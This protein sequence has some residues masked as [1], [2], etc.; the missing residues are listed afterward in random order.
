MRPK[1]N[2]C[3]S[4]L[5]ISSGAAFA[6]ASG[7]LAQGG[8]DANFEDGPSHSVYLALVGEEAGGEKEKRPAEKGA[9]RDT[10][11]KEKKKE[12]PYHVEADVTE[13]YYA[14]GD[15]VLHG[16]GNVVIVHG[17]TT[18]TCD[19]AYSYEAQRLATLLGKV[20]VRNPVQEYTLTAGYAEYHREDK[21][22]VATK[23]PR[24]VLEK[25]RPIVITSDIMRMWTD[26]EYGEAAGSVKIVSEDVDGYGQK[27]K[28][29]GKEERV[30]LS[31]KPVVRQEESRLAGDLI[32]LY[33]EGEKLRR[34]L[35]EGSAR[36]LYFSRPE[37]KGEEEEAGER[38]APGGTTAAAY[39]A[40]PARVEEELVD[41]T[42]GERIMAGTADD[43]D[44][45]GVDVAAGPSGGAAGEEEENG[46]PSGRVEAA[47]TVIDGLFKDGVL[48]QVDITG[49]AEGHY[50]PFD[51][52]GVETGEQIDAA[53]DRIRIAMNDGEVKKIVVE[54]NAE[55]IYRPAKSEGR[56]GVTQ[57]AGDRISVFVSEREVRRIVVFG[58]AHGSY[59][60]EETPAAE[61]R[62]VSSG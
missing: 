54:G 35:V 33:L 41:E 32:T 8:G 30:E 19:E 25:D 14:A 37:E 53:G 58:H 23:S 43:E 61:G 48:E 49:D 51:E 56:S 44:E 59:F 16:I 27:L 9:A 20:K 21:L 57:T 2:L 11:E 45:A 3:L 50:W 26:E 46:T 4:I 38:E 17:D 18:I 15:Q 31:G 34:A 39:E 47:G 40:A 12:I 29:F 1:R 5:L 6:G 13:G 42:T 55:G 36:I 10:A 60:T 7:S 28:Y 62:E 22:A 52:F 24:L